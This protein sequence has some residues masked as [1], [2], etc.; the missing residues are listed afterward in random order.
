VTSGL[1]ETVT[2]IE[3]VRSE[4]NLFDFGL[5]DH[6]TEKDS[7]FLKI[8]GARI[9]CYDDDKALMTVIVNTVPGTPIT[10]QN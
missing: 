9:D 4:L 7:E 5:F 2:D 1:S 3:V 8:I 6:V 10:C